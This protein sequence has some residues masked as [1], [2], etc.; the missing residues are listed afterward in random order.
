MLN[1]KSTLRL[2]DGSNTSG[3][4]LK[5][6][7][8]NGVYAV[9]VDAESEKPI[10]PSLGVAININVIPEIK[11]YVSDY[12]YC[13]FWC[14]PFFGKELKDVPEETQALYI[15]KTDGRFIVI[16]PVVND[17]YKCVLAG[18]ESGLAANLFSTY[19]K[20]YECKGLAFVYAEGENPFILT[21]KCVRTAPEILNNGTKVRAERKYP[22]LF[23]YLG[24]C[25]WDAMHMEVNE[26]GLI[27]KCMEFSEKKIPV[28]WAIIDDM[29]CEI[30]EFSNLTY[31]EMR[32]LHHASK[33]YSFKADPIRFPNG[34]EHCIKKMNQEG[35]TVGLWY[36]TTGYWSG[37]KEGGE[38][39]KLL[40]DYLIKTPS[41]LYIPSWEYAKSKAYYDKILDYFKESGA[42]FVKIDNQTMTRRFYAGLAPIGQIAKEFHDGM[43]DSVKERFDNRIINCMGMGSEDMWNRKNS[44]ISRCSDD[45]R[46]EDK[47]W[48]TKHILQ[49]SF[50]SLVQ[51]QFYWCDWDMWWTDDGQGIKNS[52]M[53]A[54]SGG[55]VYVSDEI[56]RSKKEV[57]DPLT[58]DDG[59]ILMCDK[60][61]VPTKDCL[62]ND[63]TTSGKAF[64]LQN[65]AGEYGVLAL[66]NLDEKEAEVNT[67][68]KIS[69]IDGLDNDSYAV[70][71]HF[72][73]E[74][75]IL[76]RN[77]SFDVTLSSP[78]EYKLYIFAPV[79]NGFAAIG[80]TDKFISPKTIKSIKDEKT[81]LTENGPYAFVKNGHLIFG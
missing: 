66:L 52:L 10:F 30:R 3:N 32:P 35:L 67:T 46:P 72:T 36:P 54:I 49:C 33:L 65:I 68:V 75:K 37:I 64:K 19:D 16:M 73:K 61:C 51:G 70:Y 62:T 81:E 15:E 13:E 45:F 6:S 38:A 34:L 41:D 44:P 28:K 47:S 11:S 5:I 77:E 74:L 76:S 24:W 80:R 40:S 31:K 79:K 48:F 26:Q 21:E 78:D 59:K 12:R 22:E 55:P 27:E 17:Q 20:L 9:S 23:E 8:H 42:D 39:Y 7:E 18:G 69:D 2:A 56:G 71:E 43:E 60:P 29:W 14:K 57:L 58:T 4:F 63:P 53:R 1:L 25:S 50:N